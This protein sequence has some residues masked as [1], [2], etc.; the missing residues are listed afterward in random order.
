M[1]RKDG[2][3]RSAV[4]QQYFIE[5]HRG[6]SWRNGQAPFQEIARKYGEQRSAV[7]QQYFIEL[8]R[9]KSWRKGEE[10]FPKIISRF[11]S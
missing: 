8:H 4:V 1:A 11:R 2:E 10:Y 9:G 3:Q 6:K 5:L 7:V